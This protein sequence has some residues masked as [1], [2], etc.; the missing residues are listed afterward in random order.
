MT[1]RVW[2]ALLS[3]LILA[4][5]GCTDSNPEDADGA[6]GDVD[7]MV[8]EPG[9]ETANQTA[10]QTIAAASALLTVSVP[11]GFA[12]YTVTF[13][14]TAAGFENMDFVD[15]TLDVDGDGVT[16][17]DGFGGLPS[18]YQHT[19]IESGNF[20]ALF[21]ADDGTDFADSSFNFATIAEPKV[22]PQETIVLTGTAGPG[23]LGDPASDNLFTVTQVATKMIISMEYEVTVEDDLDW[24]I[25]DP[26][27]ATAASGEKVG[28]EDDVVI[29]NAA[30]GEWNVVI[31]PYAS[32]QTSYTITITFA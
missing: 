6:G 24:T 19:F 2:L 17:T 20:T 16:E 29:Q 4:L 10:N 25:T 21:S 26:S 22:P 28:P 11:D 1:M 9:N 5:A 7:A 27:G 3:L 14:F 30:I 23:A 12:P 31:E 8:G 32:V 13:N 15:W 18:S